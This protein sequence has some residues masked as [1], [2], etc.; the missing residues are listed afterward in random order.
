MVTPPTLAIK[1]KF[2]AVVQL[3]NAV[4]VPN[5]TVVVQFPELSLLVFAVLLAGQEIV[6]ACVSTTVTVWVDVALFP[7]PSVTVQVTIVLPKAKA[8]GALLVT[9]ATEQLSAVVGVPRTTPVAV[10]AVFVVA[11][12]FDGAVMR[13]FSLSIT[14]TV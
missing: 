1:V 2:P 7:E 5:E 8:V 6:G 12:T 10:Q 11:A 14:V 4:G 9:E 3:S 13:G